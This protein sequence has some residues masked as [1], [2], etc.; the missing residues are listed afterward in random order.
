MHKRQLTENHHDLWCNQ[1]V[2]F[3]FGAGRLRSQCFGSTLA[4]PI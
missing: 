2:S 4:R 1:S 3:V